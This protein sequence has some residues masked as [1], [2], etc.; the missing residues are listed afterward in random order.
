MI[1]T[2]DAEEPLFYETYLANV[3]G[4]SQASKILSP[5]GIGLSVLPVDLT[6][7]YGLLSDQIPYICMTFGTDLCTGS[8]YILGDLQRS[9]FV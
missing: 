5:N 2:E 6:G 1:G 3:T 8:Y 9:L 7:F 4:I